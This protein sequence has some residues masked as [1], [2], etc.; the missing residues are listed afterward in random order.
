MVK[1]VVPLPEHLGA[2][3]VGAA[4]ESDDPSGL[5]ALVLI[6]DEVLGAWN[7]FFNSDLVKVEVFSMRDLDELVITND[8]PIDELGVD[9]EVVLLFDLGLGQIL[10]GLLLWLFSAAKFLS[11]SQL[12]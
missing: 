11:W 1:E 6:D 7:V 2:L 5:W 3:G 12:S 8:L 4:E 10:R 9:I